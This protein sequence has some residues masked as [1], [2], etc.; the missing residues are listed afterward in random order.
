MVCYLLTFTTL[1]GMILLF[2]FPYALG[3]KKKRSNKKDP[4]L[5]S[6][7]IF[8]QLLQIFTEYRK[9]WTLLHPND[10]AQSRNWIKI[11]GGT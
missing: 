8:H 5:Y 2:L 4:L 11:Y 9:E 6:R 10:K 7:F 3:N 1:I